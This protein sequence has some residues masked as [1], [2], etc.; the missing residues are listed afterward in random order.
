MI[1]VACRTA[2]ETVCNASWVAVAKIIAPTLRFLLD[3]TFEFCLQCFCSSDFVGSGMLY[4]VLS[5]KAI[6]ISSTP[7]YQPIGGRGRT[8]N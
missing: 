7:S 1:N 4:Y 5:A 8:A 3:F 6:T 2:I